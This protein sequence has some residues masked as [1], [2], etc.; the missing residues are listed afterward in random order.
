MTR[1]AILL[2]ED[3][4]KL[5]QRAFAKGNLSN[6]LD[7]VE[8]GQAALDYLLND[9]SRELPAVVLLDLKLPRIDGLEVLRRIREDRRTSLLPVVILTTSKEEQDI[10][11][12]YKNGA[13]SYIRKPVNFAEFSEAVVQL[14]V[15]WLAL[16]EQP[17][18]RG[19]KHG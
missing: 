18:D 1:R 12:S 7:V 3:N 2:V 8:D 6:T 16:N 13:N 4:P 5:T 14:G 17:P 11:E 15:Y 19:A 9:K 10:I